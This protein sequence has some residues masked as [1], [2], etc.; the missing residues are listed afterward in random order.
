MG[1][2][3]L[4]RSRSNSMIAGVCAGLA[5][6]LGMDPTV[7]RLLYVLLSMFSAAFPGIIFY[8]IAMFVIPL[9]E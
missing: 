2:K 3:K 7:M 4:Y 6:Y 1:P 8:I 5:E 9:E